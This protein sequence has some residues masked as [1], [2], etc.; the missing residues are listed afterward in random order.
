MRR[1]SGC[2]MGLFDMFRRVGIDDGVKEFNSTEGAVLLDVRTREEYSRGHIEN[3]VNVPLDSLGAVAGVIRDKQTPVFTYCWSGARSG[4][5]A[6]Y[7]RSLGY[8]NVKNIG[9]M[10]SY[11]GKVVQG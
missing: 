2:D 5:A 3:S 11:H 9:G 7:L 8:G 1:C 4:Q 6:G 10:S